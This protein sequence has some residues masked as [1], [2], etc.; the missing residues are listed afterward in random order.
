MASTMQLSA[1]IL[2]IPLYFEVLKL[3]LKL[4]LLF[5]IFHNSRT[6]QPWGMGAIAWIGLYAA[7]ID[8]IPELVLRLKRPEDR[9]AAI[10]S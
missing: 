6:E 3:L 7:K 9:D 1:Q 4:K 5:F 8:R 10:N 2:T